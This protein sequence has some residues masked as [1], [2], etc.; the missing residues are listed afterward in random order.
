V[1]KKPRLVIRLDGQIFHAAFATVEDL[2]QDD[3]WQAA[4]IALHETIKGHFR[5]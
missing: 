3:V 5:K 2:L 1:K 4:T